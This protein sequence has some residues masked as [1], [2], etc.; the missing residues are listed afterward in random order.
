M[1]QADRSGNRHMEQRE[2]G[3]RI[4]PVT[5]KRLF[6]ALAEGRLETIRDLRE[7]LDLEAAE[8]RQL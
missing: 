2:T 4:V 8:R 1:F 3:N 6:R 7:R 5:A